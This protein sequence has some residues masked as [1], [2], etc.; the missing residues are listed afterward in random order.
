MSNRSFKFPIVID[1]DD[2]DHLAHVNN[3]SYIKWV[4]SAIVAHWEHYAPP[5][6]QQHYLWIAMRHEIDYIQQSFREDRLIA[7]ILPFEI[8]TVRVI[9]QS[10]IKRGEDI[11][12]RAL[13][14]WCCIHPATHRP[15][16]IGPDIHDAFKI[17]SPR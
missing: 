12:A 7:E 16:R 13:S 8:K 1:D 5:S 14:T 9:Y 2:I 17:C 3:A 4:Q 11:I 15:K 10:T 6:V